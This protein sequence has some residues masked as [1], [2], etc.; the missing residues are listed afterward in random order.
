M[1]QTSIP[2]TIWIPSDAQSNITGRPMSYIEGTYSE[3]RPDPDLTPEDLEMM[4]T[5]HDTYKAVVPSTYPWSRFILS[6]TLHSLSH[7][8]GPW[9]PREWLLSL[10]AAERRCLTEMHIHDA[11][12]PHNAD[13]YYGAPARFSKSKVSSSK[14]LLRK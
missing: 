2:C 5:L 9:E 12:D 10:P 4:K 13:L 11:A 14:D 6:S 7:K 8:F 3:Q 1:I